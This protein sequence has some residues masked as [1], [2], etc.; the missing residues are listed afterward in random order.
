MSGSPPPRKAFRK[1]YKGF[2]LGQGECN[3]QQNKT[4]T[5]THTRITRTRTRSLNFK[6]KNLRASRAD[7]TKSTSLP[8]FIVSLAD[9]PVL[10]ANSTIFWM[11]TDSA[12]LPQ[13]LGSSPCPLRGP[14]THSRPLTKTSQPLD[15][16][17]ASAAPSATLLL[18]HFSNFSVP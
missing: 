12:Q 16:P 11:V 15:E 3:T 18:P 17:Q 7:R 9:R 4:T 1:C 2:Y 8:L 13:S 10:P 6:H 14:A 5:H